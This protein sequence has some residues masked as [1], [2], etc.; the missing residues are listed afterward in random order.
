MKP[1]QI[2]AVRNAAGYLVARTAARAAGSVAAS[3]LLSSS[4]ASAS[5]S[6]SSPAK[7]RHQRGAEQQSSWS[8]R[9]SYASPESDFSGHPHHP[10]AAA[11][12]AT[13]AAAAA[14]AT[15]DDDEKSWS[16]T[17]SFASPESDFIAAKKADLAAMAGRTAAGDEKSW[18]ETLSFASPE[19]DFSA[20]ADLAMAERAFPSSASETLQQQRQRQHLRADGKSWS[21]A[22]SFASP[23]SD[24][25]A[26]K[27]TDLATMA[28]ESELPI[29]DFIDHVR[30]DERL[31]TD[32][33]YSLSFA[34]T[35]SDWNS[36]SS[37]SRVGGMIDERQRRQ[38]AHEEERATLGRYSAKD[39]VEYDTRRELLGEQPE[40]EALLASSKGGGK[41]DDDDDE[42]FDFQEIYGKIDSMPLPRN[43]AEATSPSESR[44]IVVT[45]TTIPFRVVA[46][47][48]PWEGLCGYTQSEAR[49]RTLG[50]LLQGPETDGAAATAIIDKLLHG[51]EG[52]TMLTN[53]AKDGRKFQNR[54]RAGTLKNDQGKAT[55]FV[56]VLREIEESPDRFGEGEGEKRMSA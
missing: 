33:S 6:A 30:S 23:E 40:N 8:G 37:G 1:T 19:S 38:L 39:V 54:L 27:A 14:T 4:A 34:G 18:S 52:G 2:P 36:S 3:R 15:A 24:F 41:D 21:D 25:T 26:A 9:L 35:E 13:S 32:M 12:L 55:H 42:P 46:V 53:Y 17:L 49:G 47:N 51:E 22:L 50:D 45:E 28:D 7:I 56:G 11:G 44:P 43:L 31:R 29:E 48:E 5:A 16:E 20:E 10:R